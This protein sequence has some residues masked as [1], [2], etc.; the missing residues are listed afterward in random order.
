LPIV[1][2]TLLNVDANDSMPCKM[3]VAMWLNV[4]WTVDANDVIALIAVD[5]NDSIRGNTIVCNAFANCDSAFCIVDPIEVIA[6]MILD[7]AF[8]T[9]PLICDIT[10]DSVD[11]NDA[12]A[13]WIVDAMPDIVE[14]TPDNADWID[15]TML[16]IVDTM[17]DSVDW[18]IDV[19]CVAKPLIDDARLLNWLD[20]VVAMLLN[21][22]AKLLN[23]ELTVDAMPDSADV[24]LDATDWNVLAKLPSPDWIPL[25]TLDNDELSEFN[26]D[27]TV[28]DSV[29]IPLD[30]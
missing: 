5:M 11:V 26:A 27:W 22:D 9:T 16:V 6:L 7:T 18:I 3:S 20:I 29:D 15:E 25:N 2:N 24:I 19:N 10:P 12:N 28:D 14:I 21:V 8:W 4:D 30:T 23:P 1:L 17:P 13:V